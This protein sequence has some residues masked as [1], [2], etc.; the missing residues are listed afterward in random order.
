MTRKT[1]TLDHSDIARIDALASQRGLTRHAAL[2]DL[3]VPAGLLQEEERAARRHGAPNAERPG[4]TKRNK[5]RSRSRN[6][7]T[8]DGAA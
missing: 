3:I 1:T 2:A 5:R 7:R 4:T 8:P 6:V